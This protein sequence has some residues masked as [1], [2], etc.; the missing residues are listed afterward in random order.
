[1][2]KYL[3]KQ[4]LISY[5]SK[6]KEYI[7]SKVSSSSGGAANIGTL[8]RTLPDSIVDFVEISPTSQYSNRVII[9]YK[10]TV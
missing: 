4:G 5:T 3:D 7:D 6:M 9:D 10:E 8:S 2:D 1:M